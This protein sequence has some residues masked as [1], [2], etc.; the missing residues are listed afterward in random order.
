MLVW[1]ALTGTAEFANFVF[2][3]LLSYTIM[4]VS[5]AGDRGFRIYFTA[6]PKII[7]FLFYFIYETFK[8]NI[9]VAHKVLL[10]KLNLSPGI[11]AVPLDVKSDL[12]IT[13]L[14][15]LISIPPG[16]ISLDVSADKKILY[17]HAMYVE[18]KEKF[19]NE[20]KNGF[21]KRIINLTK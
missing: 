12:E 21:E 3:F 9:Q 15:N 19:I 7:S 16:T 4:W 14:A 11:I 5:R 10:P 2:G 18:D 20:I 6:I 17:V 1:V 13:I 8:A